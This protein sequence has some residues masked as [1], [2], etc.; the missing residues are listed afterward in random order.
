MLE[1]MNQS[2][3]SKKCLVCFTFCSLTGWC[4]NNELEKTDEERSRN[5]LPRARCFHARG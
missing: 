1:R 2:K 4:L 5:I 3:A